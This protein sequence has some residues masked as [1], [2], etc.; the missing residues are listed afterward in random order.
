VAVAGPFT[1]VGAEG[2]STDAEENYCFHVAIVKWSRNKGKGIGTSGAS[3]VTKL[4]G[5]DPAGVKN[6]G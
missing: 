3:G 4:G 1:F 5:Q 2:Q 6:D